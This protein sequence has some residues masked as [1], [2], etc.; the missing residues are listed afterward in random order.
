MNDTTSLESRAPLQTRLRDRCRAALLDRLTD[1]ARNMGLDQDDWIARFAAA[2]GRCHDELAGLHDRR[3]FEQA[4]GLTASRIS[5][6]HEEDLEFTLELTALA[7]RL[8]ERCGAELT[9]LH[10]RYMTL[11]DQREAAA[12][13][14]PVGPEAVCSAL[15]ALSDAA[16]FDPDQRLRFLERCA[17]P[18]ARTLNG[19][20]GELN[21]VLEAAG[22]A[23]RQTERTR[24][25][26]R[27]APPPAA[28]EPPPELPPEPP[29]PSPAEHGMAAPAGGLGELHLRMLDAQAAAQ[30]VERVFEAL[31]EHKE[32][33]PPVLAVLSRLQTPLQRLVLADDAL[34]SDPRHPARRLL[35]VTATIGLTLGPACTAE[36]PACR[37]LDA[38][39]GTL[40]AGDETSIAGYGTALAAAEAVADERRAEAEALAQAAVPIAER[41]ERREHSLIQATHLI[42]RLFSVDTHGSV[43]SF[44]ALHWLPLLARVHYNYGEGHPQW[45]TCAGLADRLARSAHPPLEPHGRKRWLEGL[46]ALVRELSQGLAAL[47]LDEAAREAALAPCLELHGALLAGTDLPHYPPPAPEQAA[48]SAPVGA[49]GLRILHHGGYAAT[50]I[51]HHAAATAGPGSWVEVDLPD[52]GALRGCI[53]WSGATQRLVIIATPDGPQVLVATRRALGELAARAACRLLDGGAL[54][55]RAAREALAALGA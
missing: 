18:L 40:L 16:G 25:A 30:T 53:V 33:A 12:E 52:G 9:R 34:L 55:D 43:R 20:Y 21:G 1:F 27:P 8:R 31:R 28:A 17:E 10:L 45:Q 37:A 7:R 35:D 44:L 15:R 54:V 48:L 22:I 13:Q 5:L 50:A 2:A 38:A 39:T 49:H 32:I 41:A 19:L 3:G 4:H 26:P 24:P 36:H 46:P 14:T 42:N 47:G 29:P 23:P 51:G 6:V 11:L